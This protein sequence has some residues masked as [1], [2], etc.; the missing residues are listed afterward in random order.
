M[1]HADHSHEGGEERA[2]IDRK[3]P[4]RGL[5]CSWKK[6]IL[7]RR[8]DRDR[9]LFFFNKTSCNLGSSLSPI[10]NMSYASTQKTFILILFSV[11][12]PLCE[13]LS[14]LLAARFRFGFLTSWQLCAFST[15][16][17]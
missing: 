4:A 7:N 10:D 2:P 17:P 5:S 9:F 3:E 16:F 8:E 12:V 14:P 1:N 11:F 15:V 6:N 13:A